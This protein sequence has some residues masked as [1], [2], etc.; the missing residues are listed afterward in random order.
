[1]KCRARPNFRNQGLAPLFAFHLHLLASARFFDEKDQTVR[2][3][4][5]SVAAF[6]VL[7]FV[8]TFPLCRLF[9]PQLFSRK[10]KT[11]RRCLYRYTDPFP[12]FQKEAWNALLT[13]SDNPF[14]RY[15]FLA[16]LEQS[17]CVCRNRLDAVPL[18]HPT[19]KH[20]L[21]SRAGVHQRWQ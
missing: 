7:P 5:A 16:A 6:R 10:V 9:P 13:D 11:C 4:S 14:V 8:R 3:S 2:T 19:G 18:C 17:G 21:R 1:M 15:E 20:A 12:S